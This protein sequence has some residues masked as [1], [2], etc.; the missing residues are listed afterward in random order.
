M[1]ILMSKNLL[2][3][4]GQKRKTS[5]SIKMAKRA[6]DALNVWGQFQLYPQCLFCVMPPTF[7][8]IV[9]YTLP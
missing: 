3:K 8:I 9:N 1:R 6:I 4:F 7:H 5:L 2:G